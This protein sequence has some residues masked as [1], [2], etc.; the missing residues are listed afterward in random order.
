MEQTMSTI[1][2][3]R[4][5]LRNQGKAKDESRT[6]GEGVWANYVRATCWPEQPQDVEHLNAKHKEL[7]QELCQYGDLTKEEKNSL[8]S[9]K[10]VIAKAI[11]NNVGVWQ[12]GDDGYIVR[13][14]VTDEPMPKGKSELQEGK[15]DFQ[16]LMGYID[17]AR[18]KLESDTLE[19]L[20]ADE[21]GE[22]ATAAS[23]VAHALIQMQDA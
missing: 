22:L 13:N 9:A 17:S 19:P 20:T 1:A 2:N 4:D 11:T 16:R 6:A 12:V 5:A 18:R 10:S 15:T 21:I 3:L 8:R 7:V 23:Q 14:V